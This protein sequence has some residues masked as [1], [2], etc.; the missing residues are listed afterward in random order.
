M[1]TATLNI[2]TEPA[3][4]KDLQFLAR[5]FGVS[6]SFII[7]QAIRETLT[8]GTIQVQELI[9]NQETIDAIEE[10]VQD[11]KNGIINPSFDNPQDF[12]KYL[13]NL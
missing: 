1:K 7:D 5:K 12:I 4:K 11:R 8:R 10:A 9:P 2:K 13:D 6:V 3:T